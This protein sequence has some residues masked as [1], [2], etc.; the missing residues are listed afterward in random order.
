MMDICKG[1]KARVTGVILD[2]Q[3]AEHYKKILTLLEEFKE[4]KKAYD[5][6]YK[7]YYN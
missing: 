7:T 4:Q 3:E 1:E 2:K 5:L 6:R